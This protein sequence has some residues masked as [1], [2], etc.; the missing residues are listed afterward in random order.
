MPQYKLV[1]FNGKGRAEVARLMFAHAGVEYE[2]YR[3]ERDEWPTLKKESPTGQA[4]YL[5][6]KDGFKLAQSNAIA[7]YLAREYDM[8]GSNNLE[9]AKIDS[10]LDSVEDFVQLCAKVIF[11]DNDEAKEKAK[12]SIIEKAPTYITMFE[13]MLKESGGTYM[14]G[15]KVSVA[16]FAVAHYLS[17][18]PSKEGMEKVQAIVDTEILRA[19]K[20]RIEALPN[21][22]KYIATR[23]VTAF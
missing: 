22:A 14:V 16:D 20:A 18:F 13:N 1:Y 3:M 5:V 9:A 19:H 2:D 15:S 8:Y 23:P 7:R 11:G 10:I 17:M 6:F 12:V 21:V 4:P